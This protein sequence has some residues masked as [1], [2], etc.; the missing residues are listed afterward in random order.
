[1]IRT[2][3]A[4]AFSALALLALAQSAFAWWAAST[5]AHQ[6][7]RSVNATRMLAEYLEI[8]GNKQ[9][10]KVWYAQRMLADDPAP[11][12]RDSLLSAMNASADALRVLADSSPPEVRRMER[13][14]VATVTQNI[15]NMAQAIHAADRPGGD[16]PPAEQWRTVLLAFDE[17]SGRDMREMLREA[18]DRHEAASLAAASALSTAL[19]RIRQIELLLAFG[20]CALALLSVLYFVRRLDQPFAK[21]TGLST[22]LAAGD[23]AARS[24]LSGRDEFARIGVLLDSM[25]VRLEEAQSRSQILQRQLDE[26]IAERTR[27]LSHAFET[28]L[29]IEARRRQFFAELSHELRTPVT[30]I[31]G[32]AEVALRGRDDPNAKAEALTRIIQAT[33]ELGDR[34]QDLLDAALGSSLGY[35]ITLRREP[36]R[37]IITA[38]VDQMQAVA[39]HRS[40]GLLLKSPNTDDCLVDVDRERLQQA[41]VIVLDN[42]LRYSPAG[43]SVVVE[44]TEDGEHWVVNIDDQG[45]GMS[46]EDLQHAFESRYR[47]TVGQTLAP[48]GQGL[49]L[50]IALRIVQ[51]QGGSIEL[52]NREGGG[53]RASIALPMSAAEVPA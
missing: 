53:L 5:A 51:A 34:V 33:R 13:A 37:A 22:A 8:S 45:P 41:L 15:A 29:G 21:L 31:R 49:G 23:F 38:A 10:L 27:S 30:V 18:V 46:E 7:E 20:V 42:A 6:A 24:G 11:M 40:L 39:A 36:L 3:L 47:G 28:L 50:P 12:V 26:L 16:L 4:V 2:R 44:L 48:Q 32:E 9:R 1:M 14:E 25:A 17:L 43:A 19:V 52:Q 35:A